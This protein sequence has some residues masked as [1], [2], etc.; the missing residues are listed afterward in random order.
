[1]QCIHIR[2]YNLCPCS[3]CKLRN[4]KFIV[5]DQSHEL[6][7]QQVSVEMFVKVYNIKDMIIRLYKY[8]A[9]KYLI[10]INL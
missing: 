4:Y 6:I 5:S 3:S 7:P 8:C 10:E 9:V 1:M 2:I